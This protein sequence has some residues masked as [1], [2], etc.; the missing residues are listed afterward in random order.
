MSVVLRKN[1]NEGPISLVAH[2]IGDVASHLDA[3]D[4]QSFLHRSDCSVLLI[5]C[6]CCTSADSMALMSSVDTS[7]NPTIQP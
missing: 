6:H 4:V 7:V 1:V 5:E 2:A 3:C